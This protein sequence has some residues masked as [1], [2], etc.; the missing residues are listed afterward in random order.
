MTTRHLLHDAGHCL[1]FAAPPALALGVLTATRSVLHSSPTLSLSAADSL[2]QL[3]W[4]VAIVVAGSWLVASLCWTASRPW[5]DRRA[6]QRLR[7]LRDLA[8]EPNRALVHLQ[9]TVWTAAAGQHAMVVNVATGV[10]HRVWIAE[11]TVPQGAFVVLERTN[12]GVRLIAHIDAQVLEAAHRHER[13]SVCA[14]VRTPVDAGLVGEPGDS[15]RLIREVE[16]FLQSI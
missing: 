13:R 9:T 2:L 4:Q 7:H 11:M 10:L 8:A 6:S 14:P 3:A 5:R 16:A 1:R 15:A 12:P